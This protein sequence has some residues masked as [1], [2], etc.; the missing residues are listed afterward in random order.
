MATPADLPSRLAAIADYGLLG[1]RLV[2]AALAAHRGGVMWIL[3]RL[4]GL[5]TVRRVEIAREIVTDAPDLFLSM[6]GD[7]EAARISGCR[8]IHHQSANIAGCANSRGLLAGASCHDAGELETA[9]EYG[10]RYAFLSPLFSTISKEGIAEPLGVPGFRRLA[11][12]A[13]IPVLALGG[14]TPDRVGEAREAGAWG[15]AVLGD[16]FL[17][18]DIERRA[19]VWCAEIERIYGGR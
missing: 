11:G 19:A 6:H 12:G 13:G 18:E 7:V 17:A 3:L 2:E 1:E 8:G 16:L 5:G 15:V 4:K 10:A 14:M 9:K